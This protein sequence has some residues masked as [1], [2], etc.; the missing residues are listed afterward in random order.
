[1]YRVTF[2]IFNSFKI[3]ELGSLKKNTYETH[4]FMYLKYKVTE[5]ERYREIFYFLVYSP[6]GWNHQVVASSFVRVSHKD[7]GV[8]V[9][10]SC[11]YAFPGALSGNW[12]GTGVSGTETG[13]Q[14][15]CHHCT[16]APL[17]NP[18]YHKTSPFIL[19]F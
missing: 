13:I 3:V 11:L 5:E 2:L 14:I 19:H 9:L 15:E 1:M 17:L 10:E 6:S 4:L 8:Q 7:V 12:V 16:N 18:L